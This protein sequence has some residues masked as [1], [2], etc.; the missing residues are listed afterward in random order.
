MAG[1]QTPRE[2]A[3]QV[4]TSPEWDAAAV[5]DELKRQAARSGAPVSAQVFFKESVAGAT[6][7]QTAS[8]IIEQAEES[9]GKQGTLTLG[10]VRASANS[11]SVSG[12]PEAIAAI[13]ESAEV[14]SVLPNAI[15][16][17]LPKPVKRQLR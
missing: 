12:D 8:R 2:N 1:K 5:K 6:L 14:K 10:K 17:V 3:S 7:P 4:Q 13:L 9:V 11:A 15:D 16:D